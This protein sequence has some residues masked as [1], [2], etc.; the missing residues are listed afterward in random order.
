MRRAREVR[1]QRGGYQSLAEVM[2]SPVIIALRQQEAAVLQ[3]EAQLQGIWAL[4]PIMLEVA[5]EKENLGAKINLEVGNIV[6][7]LENEV[8]VALSREKALAE[9]LGEAKDRSAVTNRA[10]I[11]LRQLERE[12]EANRSLYESSRA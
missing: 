12:S 6:A 4:H 8:A 11:E 10:E 5:A 2:A 3:K 7:N 9:A 1:G